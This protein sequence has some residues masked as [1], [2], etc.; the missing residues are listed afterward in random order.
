MDLFPWFLFLHVLGAIAAFGPSFSMSIIG[1][2]GGAEPQH[3]NFA[4]RVSLAI[5]NQRILPLAV[6]Q[7]ITGVGLIIL[8]KVDL[9]RNAWLGIAIVLYLIALGYAYFVQTPTVKQVIEMTSAPPPPPTPG[10]PAGPPPALRALILRAQRGGMLLAGLIA[11]IAFLMV[12]KPG[13]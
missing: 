4:T 3:A 13:V 6:V 9:T 10:A 11:V 5:S 7:G 2:M 8:G 1:Q 12:V